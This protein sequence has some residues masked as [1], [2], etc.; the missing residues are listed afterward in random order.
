MVDLNPWAIVIVNLGVLLA[1]VMAALIPVQW[2]KRMTPSRA[3][4]FQ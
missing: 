1:S 2:I 3:I 4:R